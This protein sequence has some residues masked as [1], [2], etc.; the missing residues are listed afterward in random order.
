[1]EEIEDENDFFRIG[2]KIAKKKQQLSYFSAFDH[3]EI[4]IASP[5]GLKSIIGSEGDKKR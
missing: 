2:I 4:I 1:M 5:V 3:S